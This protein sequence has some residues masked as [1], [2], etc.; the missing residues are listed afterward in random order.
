MCPSC[1]AGQWLN[2]SPTEW[3]V[4]TPRHTTIFS[5]E[6]INWEDKKD[7]LVSRKTELLALCIPNG[8][9]L[10]KEQIN[11]ELQRKEY[12]SIKGGGKENENP[13]TLTD[14]K[15]RGI[16]GSSNIIQMTKDIVKKHQTEVTKMKKRIHNKSIKNSK[17]ND[18]VFRNNIKYDRNGL[19]IILLSSSSS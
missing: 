18:Q 12:D 9:C 2:Y 10:F 8:D 1:G 15:K 3:K 6:T 5:Q 14:R 7:E 17:N 4:T 16:V 19:V 13:T 11:A